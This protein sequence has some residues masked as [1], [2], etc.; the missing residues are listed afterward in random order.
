MPARL[1]TE[2]LAYWEVC[3]TEGKREHI[4]QQSETRL[5]GRIGT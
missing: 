1:A 4:K 5:E 3:K 2:W